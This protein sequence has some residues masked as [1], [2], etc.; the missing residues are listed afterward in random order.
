MEPPVDPQAARRLRAIA[1]V[2]FGWALILLLRLVYLQ[3]YSHHDLKRIAQS[4]HERVAEIPAPR[5]MLFDRNGRPLAMSVQ[6]DSVCVN[7]LRIPD[8]G[9]ASGIL[10]GVLDL[11]EPELRRR[12]QAAKEAGRG[13]LWVARKIPAAEAD[14][15][16]TLRLD[17]VEFRKETHRHYPKGAL[18]AHV[19]GGVDHEEKG[20]AGIELG[21]NEDLE[22]IPGAV[23]MLKDVKERGFESHVEAS[24]LPGKNVTLTLD[25]RIQYAVEQSLARAVRGSGSK[26]GSVVV[27][28]ARTNEVLAMASYPTFNPNEPVRNR[29]DLSSRL[30]LAV[31]GPFEPGSVFKVVTLS[32][33]LETTRLRPES[34]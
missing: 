11:D 34:M 2:A 1:R 17:W 26:T 30:N 8:P 19:V 24:P 7:P 29:R 9:V 21:L 31:S 33:A 14:R 12:I 15:L 27:L 5:G 18:A 28:D 10:A 3:V 23:R 13:F 25:E 16:R 20:N 6:M 4:Q 32:S 22:G